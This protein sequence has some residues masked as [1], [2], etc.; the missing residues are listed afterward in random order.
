MIAGQYSDY[1]YVALKSYKA[2]P[3]A[4]VGRANAIMGGVAKQFSNAEL[5]ELANYVASMPGVLKTVP[6]NRFR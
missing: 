6:Q 2:E 1:L 5:K 3:S 4:Q